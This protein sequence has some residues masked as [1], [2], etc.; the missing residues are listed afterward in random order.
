VSE[1]RDS[2]SAR[3]CGGGPGS[4]PTTDATVALGM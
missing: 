4:G 3:S 2:A 1:K